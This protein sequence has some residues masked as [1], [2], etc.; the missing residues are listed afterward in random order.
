MMRSRAIACCGLLSLAAPV[1]AQNA[2][3]NWE[4]PHVH[5]MDITSGEKLVT[6]N[7]ADNRIEVYQIDD[8]GSRIWALL[9]QPMTVA[10]LCKQLVASYAVDAETCQQDTLDFLQ[11]LYV[12]EII[13]IVD[14]PAA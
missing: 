12:A 13:T 3:V 7:T 5:P 8:I 4:S 9:E 11:E 1:L 10:D 2:F 6:V 14:T